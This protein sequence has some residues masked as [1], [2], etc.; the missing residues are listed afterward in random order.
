M[1][2]RTFPDPTHDPAALRVVKKPVAVTVVFADEEGVCATL[3]GAVAYRAGDAIVTAKTGESWPIARAKFDAS[4]EAADKPGH[5]R[6]RPS[7]V[8]ALRLRAP[9]RVPVGDAGGA[10]QAKPGDWLIAYGDGEHGV[11]KDAIFRATYGPA[12]GERRWPPA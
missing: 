3:E 9:A 8:H 1:T 12:R 10:L 5:Y 7:V 2:G 4:Y 11:V 6:K